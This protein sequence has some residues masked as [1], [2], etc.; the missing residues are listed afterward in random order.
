[1]L[2]RTGPRIEPWGTLLVTTDVNV[3]S[4]FLK[5][6]TKLFIKH[7]F[8]VCLFPFTLLFTFLTMGQY[9]HFICFLGL[10]SVIESHNH[11]SWK[12]PSNAI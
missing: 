10:H 3:L 11:S 1:M 12:G 8:F 2:N 6:R 5:F 4:S 9:L 7:I